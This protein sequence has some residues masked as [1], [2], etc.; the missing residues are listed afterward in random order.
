M[1]IVVYIITMGMNKLSTLFRCCWSMVTQRK[2]CNAH[3]TFVFYVFII[4]DSV[5]L[6]K[7]KQ[8]KKKT[9]EI[10]LA[11]NKVTFMFAL[12]NETRIH[13]HANLYA[14]T[15]MTEISLN[16]TLNNQIHLTSPYPKQRGSR[17]QRCR[18]RENKCNHQRQKHS[19]FWPS[20]LNHLYVTHVVTWPATTAVI[21]N[22]A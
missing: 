3:K 13:S 22:R 4:T 1:S 12:C 17:W 8:K 2:K 19:T 10:W 15:Y 6:W 11:R 9:P 21:S 20:C 18:T 5:V 14:V 16:V 7:K